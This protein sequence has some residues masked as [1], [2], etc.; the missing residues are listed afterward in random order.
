[1]VKKLIISPHVDDE[2]LACGGI[3]DENSFVYYCGIGESKVAPDPVHRIPMGQRE[4]ELRKVSEFLG[5]R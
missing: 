1:M 5:F 2:V 3:L 4:V